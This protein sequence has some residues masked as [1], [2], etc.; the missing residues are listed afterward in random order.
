MLGG[1]KC[2]AS[3]PGTGQGPLCR[4]LLPFLLF[5]P[6]FLSTL[7]TISLVVSFVS[8]PFLSDM[9]ISLSPGIASCFPPPTI[10]SLSFLLCI[11]A[12]FVT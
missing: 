12:W 11:F 4:H 9:L 10:Y 6:I 3:G 7:V 8:T 2:D 1:W 5:P